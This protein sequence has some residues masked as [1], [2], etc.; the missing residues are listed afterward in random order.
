[1][2]TPHDSQPGELAGTRAGGRARKRIA[3][4]EDMRD[5]RDGQIVEEA[6]ARGGTFGSGAQPA[7][8]V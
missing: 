1:M 8:R 4:A 7:K 3:R 5:L 6:A 2:R